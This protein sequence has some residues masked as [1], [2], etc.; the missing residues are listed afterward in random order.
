MET[1][2]QDHCT[3]LQE[4]ALPLLR[5]SKDKSP[6]PAMQGDTIQDSL[7]ESSATQTKALGKNGKDSDTFLQVLQDNSSVIVIRRPDG[8]VKIRPPES[9]G[10]TS[11]LHP[12]IMACSGLSGISGTANAFVFGA[13]GNTGAI[14]L[15][16]SSK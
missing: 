9:N 3:S 14:W 11:E 8:S 10:T 5:P 13:Q 1:S 12:C 16:E 2:I 15:I 4:P 6:D 7:T